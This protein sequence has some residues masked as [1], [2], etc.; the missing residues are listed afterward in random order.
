MAL[1]EKPVGVV[2]EKP[3]AKKLLKAALSK[4]R[5]SEAT[6]SAMVTTLPVRVADL[7]S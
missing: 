2:M 1:S 7:N 6:A 4:S 3:F 5:S